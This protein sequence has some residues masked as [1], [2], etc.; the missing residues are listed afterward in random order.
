MRNICRAMFVIGFFVVIGTAGSSDMGMIGGSQEM[1]QT[2]SGL[3][4]IVTG[5]FGGKL[6]QIQ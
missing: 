4:M 5:F 6:W 3:L 2:V 1:I